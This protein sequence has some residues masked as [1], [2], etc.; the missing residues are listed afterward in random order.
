M[1]E[2]PLYRRPEAPVAQ[3]V[4]D[5][6]SRMTL[7]EKIVEVCAIWDE[8]GALMG[9][10]LLPDAAL[11]AARFPHGAGHVSRP[12]DSKGEG[13]NSA[14]GGCGPAATAE[15]VNAFQRHALSTR[16]GI[17]VL[18]HEEGLHGY[19]APGAT[20]FPQAIALA[21]SFDPDLVREVNAVTAR[22]M[23]A[24]GAVLALTPVLD[25]ARDPRWGRIEETFGEDPHLVSEMGLAAVRG[26]QG[27]APADQPLPPG[28]VFA[29]L[30]HLAGHGQPEGG[31]NVGPA[32]LAEREL[33]EQFLLPFERAVREAGASLVMAS[34]NEVDGLPSH[35]NRWLLGDVL[36]GEWGFQ[37]AVVGDYF[38]VEQLA[39][40]HQVVTGPAEA[41][42]RALAAGVDADLPNGA[43]YVH[44]AAEV[45]AGR[46]PEVQLDTAVRR[47]LTLKFRAGLFEQPYADAAAAEA[48]THD[49][50]AQALALRAAERSVVLLKN[51]G[52]LPLS[53]PAAGAAHRPVWA[54]VGPNAAEARLGSYSGTP[55]QAL[56]LFD[57]LRRVAGET[58]D[59]RHAQG[60]RITEGDDWWADEVRL[61]SREANLALI[62]E[63]VAVAAAADVVLLAVGD[64]LRTSREAWAAHH[65]GD[66]SDLGLAG[67]QRLLF[68][69]LAAL[70][71]PVVV[72]LINGRPVSEP[73]LAE[74]AHAIVEAWFPGEMGGLALARVLTGA[75]NPGAKLPVTVPR[76]VGQLPLF[77]NHKPSAR[78]GYLFDDIAP[79]YPFGHGL[80]YT[81]FQF[82]APRLSAAAMPADGE[83][84][85][86]VEVTNVGTRT[87][88]EVV[89]LYVRDCVASVAQPVKALKGFARITLAP[90]EVRTVH[91]VLRAASLALWNERM[92]RV[93]EPG[94][95]E[96]MV[97][98]DSVSLQSVRLVVA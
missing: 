51:D 53:L 45:R 32:P 30:K 75:V 40:L 72:V 41:A 1:P 16:L 77:Y 78:R 68:E 97:G 9:P 17:P 21:G 74:R 4:E 42:A 82:G 81:R 73:V 15:R 11:L 63:A 35:V 89:Q 64:D 2:M 19:A 59:L 48:A 76:H 98:P 84:T 87:G 6:L 44:L 24:R 43:A 5:L 50:A 47:M 29:T 7:E 14:V 18:C 33:R 80:S 66:R 36:R 13:V 65:L 31:V 55:P 27:E 70:G 95:F 38:A 54:V 86:S 25:I 28:K 20:S 96:V 85:V 26:L 92:Q 39:S 57:G 23:R 94:E 88:D 91:L 56:S 67:E 93:V 49:A 52:T 3:R 83:V 58:V 12:S 10:D 60:V 69:R 79:L 71:K 62:D 90:G 46:V 37:G 34:Y 61:A 8:K 22:E